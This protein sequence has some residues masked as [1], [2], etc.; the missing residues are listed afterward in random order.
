MKSILSAVLALGLLVPQANAGMMSAMNSMKAGGLKLGAAEIH[1]YAGVS[2]SYDSNIYSV[3]KDE[4][5]GVRVGGG[6][7]S[8]WITKANAGLK[9]KLPVTSM[10]SFDGGYGAAGSFYSKQARINDYVEQ[11]ADLGY[12]YKGPMGL[13]GRLSDTFLF[14]RDPAFSEQAGER[15]QR[16]QNGVDAALNY[17]PEGGRLV[18]GLTG[19]HTAHKYTGADQAPL[20]NRYEQM[21][22]A[23]AGFKVQP[24]TTVWLGYRRGIVHYTADGRNAGNTQSIVSGDKNNKSHYFEG[25]VDGQLAPK[26]KGS[27]STGVSL[28]KYDQSN[29]GRTQHSR[30]F[31]AG[32]NLSWTPRETCLWTLGLSRTVNE[33][34]FG[35]NRF[36]IENNGNIAMQHKFPW[37]LTGRVGAGMTVSKYPETTNSGAFR[38]N[39][40][41][42]TYRQNVGVDYGINDWASLGLDYNHTERFS[43]FSG[44]YNYEK[45]VTMLSA[46][47][48]F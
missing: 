38:A 20:L 15:Q 31:I 21:L 10:H 1:P 36:S 42:D 25:G 14:T 47:L 17:A 5:T 27:V 34:T 9:F 7:R 32:A 26:L 35:V 45:H 46:K 12:N 33:S 30:N 19:N 6:V 43:N 13:S 22:G 23:K 37:R 11:K 18:F 16:W 28:R 3:P 24:K 48:T 29:A 41:D 2:E 40:R 44:Q 8:A 4:P 39:R